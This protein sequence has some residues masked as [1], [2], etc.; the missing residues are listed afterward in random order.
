[1]LMLF[2]LAPTNPKMFRQQTRAIV[3]LEL[4]TRI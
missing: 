1:M 3:Q 2:M 4:L